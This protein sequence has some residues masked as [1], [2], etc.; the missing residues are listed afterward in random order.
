MTMG[1]FIAYN[2]GFVLAVIPC[3]IIFARFYAFLTRSTEILQRLSKTEPLLTILLLWILPTL[4]VTILVLHLFVDR[5]FVVY[6]KA[7]SD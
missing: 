2:I 6:K 5:Y 3:A 4:A 7:D 1:S